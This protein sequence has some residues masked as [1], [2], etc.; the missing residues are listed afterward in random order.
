MCEVAGIGF[1]PSNLGLAVAL[2]EHND[3]APTGD[4]IA[5][6]FFEK[7][8]RFGWHRDMLIDGATVQVS[9]L[10]DLV[11]MRKP[12]SEFSFLSYLHA[13]GRLVDF[14]NHKSLF[15]SRVEFNDYLEWVAGHF[16]HLVDYDSEVVDVRPVPTGGRIR[17]LEVSV[18][19]GGPHG[20]LRV[21]RARSVVVATG[22]QPV[23]PPGV[24]AS[25]RIWHS[26]ELLSRIQA[27]PGGRPRRVVVIGAGQSAAEAV[28]YVHRVFTHTEVCSVF[29]RY[30]YS[31]ADDSAFANRVFDPEAV[32]TYYGAREEVKRTLFGY[33]RNTNY[34]VVDVELID[35]LYRRSYQEK[36]NGHHRLRMLN[37]SRVVEA[38]ETASGV[39]VAV[40]S[41]PTGE[42]DVLDADV[43]IYATGYREADVFGLLG[44]MG[45]Y[46]LRDDQG[47]PRVTRDY[48]VETVDGVDCGI[49]LQGPTEHTHG[50]S[51]GLLSTI[52][53]RSAEI[54]RSIA[55]RASA[56]GRA[57]V[58]DRLPSAKAG[59]NGER[60]IPGHAA[61]A[62]HPPGE[63]ASSEVRAGLRQWLTEEGS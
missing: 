50:I 7:Q 25:E 10:K 48:R 60:L 63:L 24:T 23:L 28:E 40:E 33:H 32:D 51:S 54:T 9:F 37:L 46:C 45:E 15:P 17:S 36:V 59:R 62:R 61:A 5:A 2:A 26:D 47:R 20:E 56:A 43:V 16:P 14:I 34:S 39:R 19:T 38:R 58:A 42:I 13:K 22:L 21:R 12:S 35:E 30:G 3:D 1:G 52:A 44:E 11:T 31:P 8:K 41:L 18:R 27:M 49:Y 53:V 57:P 55:A 29:A 6:I 4:R